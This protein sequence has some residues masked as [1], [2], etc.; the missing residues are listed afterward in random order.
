MTNQFSVWCVSICHLRRFH[1]PFRQH[2]SNGS[3]TSGIFACQCGCATCRFLVVRRGSFDDLVI[4]GFVGKWWKHGKEMMKAWQRGGNKTCWNNRKQGHRLQKVTIKI[5]LESVFAVEMH[6]IQSWSFFWCLACGTCYQKILTKYPPK[7]CERKH[8]LAIVGN[9]QHRECQ[10]NASGLAK[11]S[12]EISWSL[13]W[14]V[15]SIFQP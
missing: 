9:T 11:S 6:V 15:L 12:A 10:W 4:A 1:P 8:R 3:T 5:A 14:F 13:C 2:W 7:F